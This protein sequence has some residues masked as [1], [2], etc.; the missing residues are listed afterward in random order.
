LSLRSNPGL[1]L[2]NAFGV[3]SNTKMK[4]AALPFFKHINWRPDS[5]ELRRFALAMLIGFTVLGLLSAWRA[6]GITTTP[7][8]LWSIGVVLAIAAFVPGL[9]RVA[10]LV[11]YLPTSII[12]YVV[13]NVILALM[14]FL[15]I[16]PLGIILKLMG[17]DLLQQKRQKAATQWTPIKGAKTEDSYYRQF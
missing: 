5:R 17:K 1:K 12:G 4:I 2:A 13:S 14:F 10:Y 7:V 16:T 9:G 15:V 3:N 6:G 8:V 11:V